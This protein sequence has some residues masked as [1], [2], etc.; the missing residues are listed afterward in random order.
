MATGSRS[1]HMPLLSCPVCDEPSWD[2]IKEQNGNVLCF[3]KKKPLIHIHLSARQ[4]ICSRNGKRSSP[5]AGEALKMTRKK[6]EGGS[7][8]DT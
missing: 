3:K 6:E 2:T 5:R 8:G 4:M 1:P 7:P